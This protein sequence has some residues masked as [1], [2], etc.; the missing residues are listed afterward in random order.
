MPA[1]PPCTDTRHAVPL[2]PRCS[3]EILSIAAMLSVPNVFVRPR[4]QVKAADEA[5]AKFTHTDGDHLTLLNVYHAWKGV[6]M[7]ANWAYEHFLNQRALQ[8]GDSVRTQLV[9]DLR[10][11]NV[12]SMRML[13][14]EIRHTPS[15]MGSRL[16]P[17]CRPLD[18]PHA[19]TRA[20]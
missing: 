7:D 4:E 3:N 2:L 12:D 20:D 17:D 10:P 15:H 14:W 13:S 5:K 11:L 6:G 16:L 19:A 9:S 1:L 8:S 18:A